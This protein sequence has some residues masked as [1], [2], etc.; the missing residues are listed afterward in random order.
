MASCAKCQYTF[1]TPP[2]FRHDGVGAEVYPLDKFDLHESKEG[3][4]K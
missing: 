1:F 2:T 4:K 3:P